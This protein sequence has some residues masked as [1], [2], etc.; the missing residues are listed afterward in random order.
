MS[1]QALGLPFWGMVSGSGLPTGPEAGRAYN[2]RVA[3]GRL[4]QVWDYADLPAPGQGGA[5]FALTAFQ[6][7]GTDLLLAVDLADRRLRASIMVGQSTAMGYYSNGQ[8]AS[9]F[10]TALQPAT[11]IAFAAG[12]YTDGGIHRAYADAQ[13]NQ[14]LSAPARYRDMDARPAQAMNSLMVAAEDYMRRWGIRPKLRLAHSVGKG[15]RSLSAFLPSTQEYAQSSVV[16]DAGDTFPAGAPELFSN[17]LA[18]VDGVVA[19]ATSL[20]LTPEVDEIHFCQ[21]EGGLRTGGWTYINGTPAGS[22]EADYQEQL[23]LLVDAWQAAVTTRTSQ[24]AAPHVFLQQTCLARDTTAADATARANLAA[25]ASA[26]VKLARARSDVTCAVARYMAPFTAG[27]SIHPAENEQ[28]VIAGAAAQGIARARIGERWFAPRVNLDAVSGL[29][30]RSPTKIRIP[31][32]LPTYFAGQTVQFDTD[33]LGQSTVTGGAA[34][35]NHGFTL[36]LGAGDAGKT[37]AAVSLPGGNALDVDLSAELTD[38]GSFLDIGIHNGVTTVTAGISWSAARTDVRV[39]SPDPANPWKS[40]GRSTLPIV[41]HYLCRERLANLTELRKPTA[42][43][44]AMAAHPALSWWVDAR[45][46]NCT[47][48]GGTRIATLKNRKAGAATVFNQ[49]S[50][51]ALRSVIDTNDWASEW[52]QGDQRTGLSTVSATGGYDYDAGWTAES[53]AGNW[54]VAWTGRVGSLQ[55]AKSLWGWY[56][57]ASEYIGVVV[58]QSPGAESL[59]LH[60]GAQGVYLADSAGNSGWSGALAGLTH[61]TPSSASQVLIMARKTGDASAGVIELSVN[62]NVGFRA[63]C[64]ANPVDASGRGFRLLRRPGGGT[65]QTI[66]ASWRGAQ[67]WLGTT[68]QLDEAQGLILRNWREQALI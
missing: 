12:N 29:Y 24:A 13:R 65:S 21:G 61:A 42:T 16:V 34:P 37:I 32:E 10:T 57:G 11:L 63:A 60:Y 18:V 53:P 2:A 51:G 30:W 55:S 56:D 9:T 52:W 41:W 58:S 62:G 33:Y 26:H 43:E 7:A 5:G 54:L 20:G 49:T 28:C 14:V 22:T 6:P 67:L 1:I 25:V 38:A 39:P 66:N 68:A 50:A 36:E 17:F 44:A 45:A 31:V 35:T 4:G 40:R 47:D 48:E 64:G 46:A 27:S 3:G 19:L 23:G 15:A 59:L 8:P